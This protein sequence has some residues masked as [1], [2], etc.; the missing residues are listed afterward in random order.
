MRTLHNKSDLRQQLSD[1]RRAGERIALVPT[2]G[3][4]HAGH[5]SL[6]ELARQHADRV[7]ATVFVNPTQFGAGE[8][9][10]NYPRSLDSDAAQLE[11]EQVDLLFAPNEAEI[12]P[13]GTT[14]ATRVIVPELGDEFCGAGRPGHFDGVT[15]VVARLF[16]LVQPE[17]AV[18]GQKDFQQQLIIRRMVEDLGLPID[19]VAAPTVR[20]PSGLAMSSRNA[21]LKPAERESAAAIHRVLQDIRQQL[22]A[23][24]TDFAELESAAVEELSEHVD[25]V[26]YLAIRRAADLSP[27][28][29]TDEHLVILVAAHLAGVRLIDNV[30][31]NS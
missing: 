15:S 22:L 25:S 3:S 4:L 30:L 7:V 2:M 6:V 31:V 13:F 9:F 20:E 27:P 11:T 21:Y 28:G 8:D 17:V 12:Y 1:W 10:D 24:K 16:A 5:L 19:I 23:G 18:F 14:A 26:E 29:P